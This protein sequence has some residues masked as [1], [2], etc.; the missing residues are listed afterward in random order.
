[1]TANARTV[2]VK[3][4]ATDLMLADRGACTTQ[5]PADHNAQPLRTYRIK[6]PYTEGSL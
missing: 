5:R 6:Q 1:V 4:V 3:T 2:P